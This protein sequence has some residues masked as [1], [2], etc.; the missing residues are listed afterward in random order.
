MAGGGGGGDE[1]EVGSRNE[2]KMV[3]FLATGRACKQ[4]GVILSDLSTTSLQDIALG[5]QQRGL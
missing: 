4:K 3:E 1:G 2:M 5:Y